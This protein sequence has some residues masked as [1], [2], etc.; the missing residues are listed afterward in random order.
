MLSS[1]WAQKGVITRLQGEGGL[2]GYDHTNTKSHTK[3]KPLS[4]LWQQ[5][6]LAS[7]HDCA[8]HYGLRQI[9]W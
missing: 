5:A 1:V 6:P 9:A 7:D 3:A 2:S 8:T 4:Q